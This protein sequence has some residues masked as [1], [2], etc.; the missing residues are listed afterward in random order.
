MFDELDV[1]SGY[2]ALGL[3]ELRN[4]QKEIDTGTEIF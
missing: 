2:E 3:T 1:F 4:L